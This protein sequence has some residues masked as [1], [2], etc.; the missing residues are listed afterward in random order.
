MAQREELMT[1][2]A[3]IGTKCDTR[4]GTRPPGDGADTR[5]N[6][7]SFQ[8]PEEE[9]DNEEEEEKEE[10]EEEQDVKGKDSSK[11]SAAKQVN[12][13]SRT[14]ILRGAP[15]SFIK[16]KPLQPYQFYFLFCADHNRSNFLLNMSILCYFNKQ[17]K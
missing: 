17:S 1:D 6:K 2:G 14:I 8:Q 7:N 4:G 15:P 13:V 16:F 10:Q 3:S 9:P 12:S 11:M 5:S